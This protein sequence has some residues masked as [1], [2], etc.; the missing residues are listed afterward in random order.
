MVSE[1]IT[2]L[3]S[4]HHSALYPASFSHLFPLPP[5]DISLEDIHLSPTPFSHLPVLNTSSLLDPVYAA[6]HPHYVYSTVGVISFV[7]LLLLVLLLVGFCLA[8]R[9]YREFRTA[10]LG[11]GRAV[12]V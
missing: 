5:P 9:R 1:N 8:T 12:A 6:V 2:T 11:A 7:V 4:V 3:P 10:V